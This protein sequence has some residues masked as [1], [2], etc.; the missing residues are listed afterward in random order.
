[1]A[2]IEKAIRTCWDGICGNK[3]R[4]LTPAT[5]CTT[6]VIALNEQAMA[7]MWMEHLAR[8]CYYFEPTLLEG[9]CERLIQGW[10]P[11]K[12]QMEYLKTLKNTGDDLRNFFRLFSVAHEVPNII[13]SLVKSVGQIRD[14]VRLGE[15]QL[16]RKQAR[17]ILDVVPRC[18]KVDWPALHTD[19][20]AKARFLRARVTRMKRFLALKRITAYDFHELKKDFRLVYSVYYH[21]YPEEA[22]AST[23]PRTFTGAKK[24]IKKMHQV[25]L[26]Q[27]YKNGVKYRSTPISLPEDFRAH[28]LRFL[29]TIKITSRANTPGR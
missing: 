11:T 23:G 6:P 18:G 7:G 5:S 14:Q 1:L 9:I 3:F 20:A 21:L 19:P 8:W 16:A 28:M 13:Q 10:G 2:A 27:K 25:L 29:G 17:K 22:C 12:G 15:M 26:E 24:L 4:R